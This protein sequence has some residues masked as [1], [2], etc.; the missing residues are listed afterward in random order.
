MRPL[1]TPKDLINVGMFGALYIV[2][3]YSLVMVGIFNLPLIPIA[4][5]LA[6]VNGGVVYTLFLTRVK[7]AGMVM[8]MGVLTML[9][10]LIVGKP[11]T[12]IPVILIGASLAELCLWLGKYRS[13]IWG[14][15]SYG[16]VALWILG[17]M[18][19][20]FLYRHTYIAAMQTKMGPEY[21]QTMSTLLTTR[22]LLI[23][24]GLVFVTALISGYLGRRVLHK[25]FERAGIA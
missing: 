24:F 4:F 21:A 2:C 16:F 13:A 14:V 12:V 3:V 20:L 19:P 5:A 11:W 22:Y 6:T 9:I 8:L 18:M 25:H 10:L 1:F 7:R 23:V 17:P 15:I